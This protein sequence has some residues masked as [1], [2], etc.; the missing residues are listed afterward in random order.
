MTRHEKDGKARRRRITPWGV[1]VVICMI[2]GAFLAACLVGVK[3]ESYRN[4]SQGHGPRDRERSGLLIDRMMRGSSPGKNGHRAGTESYVDREMIRFPLSAS[5]VN[6]Q[7]RSYYGLSDS[8]VAEIAI[9]A[10]AARVRMITAMS[11]A[12]VPFKDA[13]AGRS[14]LFF[15]ANEELAVEVQR[16]LHER[17]AAL[18]SEEFA[19]TSITALKAD[20]AYLGGGWFDLYVF[21]VSS[22]EGRGH[23]GSGPLIRIEARTGE[24]KLAQAW[25]TSRT[26]LKD[27]F[28]LDVENLPDE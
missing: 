19:Q 28:W 13:E 18:V 7:A 21:A 23:A 9:A 12:M 10:K 11:E 16:E 27:D 2:G 20:G 5:G 26:G 8:Q 15:Q 17:L 25:T 14:G 22:E 1:L 24:G 6:R 3:V 4:Q